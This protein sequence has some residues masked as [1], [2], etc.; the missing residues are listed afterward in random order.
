VQVLLG[1][2]RFTY[3]LEGKQIKGGHKMR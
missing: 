1:L 3:I 2:L